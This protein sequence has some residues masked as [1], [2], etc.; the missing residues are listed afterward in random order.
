MPLLQLRTSRAS[1]RA[2]SLRRPNRLGQCPKIRRDHIAS[3]GQLGKATK[4]A[5]PRLP[6]TPARGSPPDRAGLRPLRHPRE[7]LLAVF[8]VLAGRLAR[9][10]SRGCAFINAGPES[11]LGSATERATQEYRAWVVEVST[12]QARAA[13]AADPEALAAQLILLYDGAAVACEWR[14]RRSPRQRRARPLNCSWTRQRNARDALAPS[15]QRR[16]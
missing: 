10:E 9:P 2:A 5:D 1:P 16:S 7:R 11:P 12:D 3:P 15:S 8:D 6:R 13:G 14:A 4:D